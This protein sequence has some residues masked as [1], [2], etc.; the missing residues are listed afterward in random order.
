MSLESFGNCVKSLQTENMNRHQKICILML[1]LAALAEF[2]SS[3]KREGRT[4]G[5]HIPEKII[6]GVIDIVQSHKN[7][8]IAGTQPTYPLNQ[9]F[10]QQQ[11]P[12]YQQWNGQSTFQNQGFQTQQPFQGTQQ[13]Q[14]QYNYQNGYNQAGT[15]PQDGGNY[16]NHAY[17]AVSGQGFNQGQN[18]QGQYQV[19]Y[20]N[21]NQFGQPNN[22]FQNT[23]SG[24]YTGQNQYQGSSSSFQGQSGQT[25]GPGASGSGQFNQGF[26]VSGGQS[27]SGNGQGPTCVCQAWTKP[28]PVHD[29]LADSPATE[30]SEKKEE[31]S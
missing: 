18:Q 20:Q 17:P 9:Q 6:G 14:G 8:P 5:L 25:Q 29:V 24:Y 7:K 19:V 27:G 31:M 28:Q 10:N 23:Q 30:K 15:Y 4:G 13:G 3:S 1:S 12:Q 21:P 11:Y 16:N 2:S 22:Q 26:L